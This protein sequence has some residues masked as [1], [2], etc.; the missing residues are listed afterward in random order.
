M[1]SVELDISEISEL[2]A[3]SDFENC[4][5]TG[6]VSVGEISTGWISK[7]EKRRIP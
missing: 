4:G 2:D 6:V 1:K 5:W 3:D 7:L